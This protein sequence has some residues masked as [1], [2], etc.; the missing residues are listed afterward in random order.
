M[1]N[2]SPNLLD[3]GV[4]ISNA[5]LV[6]LSSYFMILLE[7]LELVTDKAFISEEAQLK[8]VHYLQYIVTGFTQTEE[9]LLVLNMVL[10]GLSP[11]APITSGIEI[12]NDHKQLIDSL[13]KA[14]ISH[15][16]DI[17]ASSIQGFRGN[18][19]V[20]EGVLTETKDSLQLIIEKRG[21][22]IL[23][24]KS[25]FSFSIIKLPWMSKPLHINWPY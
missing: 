3:N 20:R 11:N 2:T 19:L 6:I 17:G 9:S 1:K 12:S 23:I 22:D 13:I 25:P 15:W 7:R 8:A 10:C 18:W 5:G 14:A 4:H 16:P 21:Y 24:S